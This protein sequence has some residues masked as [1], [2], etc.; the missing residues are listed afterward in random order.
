MRFALVILA[1]ITVTACSVIG[2]SSG[3]DP[4]AGWGG[5]WAG[6]YYGAAGNSGDMEF[7]LSTDAAG[8]TL[9]VARF[10]TGAG[11][12]RARLLDPALTPDSM[13]TSMMFDRMS[14]EIR[15]ARLQ[16]RAEGTYLLRA[17]TS[18]S[19]I[20]SGTWEVERRVAGT[21]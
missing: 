5:S 10:Y 21:R 8:A 9:G 18:G 6:S 2:G 19:V 11:V 15:G 4:L 12:D 1:A 14:V 20:D 7:E 13:E 16:D 3:P 17:S